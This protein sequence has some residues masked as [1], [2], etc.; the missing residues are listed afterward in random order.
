MM[1]I[2]LN[3]DVKYIINRLKKAG[4]EAYAV[5]GCIRDSIMGLSPGDWDITTNAKP[6]EI[7]K[8]FKRSIDT[9]IEHGTVTLLINKN[10]I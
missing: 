5:G 6:Y 3:E 10:S 2:E 9:G 4:F 8:Y 1:H 7:K